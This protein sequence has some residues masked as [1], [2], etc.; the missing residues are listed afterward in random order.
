MSKTYWL[1][2]SNSIP[3]PEKKEKTLILHGVNA[4]EVKELSKISDNPVIFQLSEADLNEQ[5]SYFEKL[6]FRKKL[7]LYAKI[8]ARLDKSLKLAIPVIALYL[9]AFIFVS[10]YLPVDFS[11]LMAFAAT[12]ATAISSLSRLFNGDKVYGDIA[13][14]LLGLVIGFVVDIIYIFLINRVEHIA[15]FLQKDRIGNFLT[16]FSMILC[17]IGYIRDMLDSFISEIR[18]DN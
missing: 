13:C 17:F 18:S 10:G 8:Y 11:I 9:I 7:K 6:S 5:N 3:T 12:G 4:Y 2:T 1:I 16:V 15:T 14:L